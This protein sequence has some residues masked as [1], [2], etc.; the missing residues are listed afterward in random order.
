M[1]FLVNLV[2]LVSVMAMV[3]MMAFLYADILETK[4]EIK[5]KLE[6]IDRLRK[7]VEKER[8]KDSNDTK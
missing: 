3:L 6:K 5:Q 4:H 1:G 7:E 2:A 8:K